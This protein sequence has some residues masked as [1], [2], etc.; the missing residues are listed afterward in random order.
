MKKILVSL[1]VIASV[2]ACTKDCEE[3]KKDCDPAQ[4]ST[5]NCDT[6]YIPPPPDT[7]C[8]TDLTKGL[9]AYFPFNGNFNDESG[10][11]NNA[12]SKN[13]A[14]LTTDFL[15][16]TGKA[17]GFDGVND[18]LIVPGSNKLNADTITV[19]F[20]VMVNTINRRH[21]G[22]SRANYE[23]VQSHV[24]AIQQS[25]PSDNKW[26]FAVVP[27]TDDCSKLYSYDPGGAVYA[28]GPT[29][30]G[31][32]Y[33][34]VASFAGGVQKIYLDG[35]LQSSTT[36]TFTKVKSC[37]NGDLLIGGWW[38]ND[39]LSIDGKIDEVRLYKRLLTDCEISKLSEVFKDA[40]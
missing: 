32:W 30:P 22:V 7:S 13:G 8:K 40:Q 6:I 10:N 34:I 27:G 24:F 18:Y 2:V 23:T 38:K 9:L 31:R 16:R 35:V 28:S 5:C 17:A 4:D 39:I 29:Q 12:T 25:Q 14:Y 1:I 26:N 19:S 33:N 20:Q 36:R 11:G 3:C 15:G 21:A 37:D